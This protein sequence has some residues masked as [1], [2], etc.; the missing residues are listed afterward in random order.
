MSEYKTC[1]FSDTYYQNFSLISTFHSELRIDLVLVYR[2]S[3]GHRRTGGRTG[4]GT[5]LL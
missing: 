4:G 2:P 1:F 3:R 5:F